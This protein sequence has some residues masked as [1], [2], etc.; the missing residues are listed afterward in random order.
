MPYRNELEQLRQQVATLEEDVVALRRENTDLKQLSALL[1]EERDEIV[2][3]QKSATRKR[4][5]A[6]RK[7]RRSSSFGA[8]ALGSLLG[9]GIGVVLALVTQ[10][11]AIPMG[12]Q[13]IGALFGAIAGYARPV[14]T[15]S[16]TANSNAAHTYGLGQ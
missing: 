8:A 1:S 7:Q 3:S 9:L 12:T 16:V 2:A 11:P 4:K 14:S 5:K 6:K 13:L 10:N 15:G